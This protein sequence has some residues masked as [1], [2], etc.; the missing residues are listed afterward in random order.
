MSSGTRWLQF[1]YFL[2]FC[3]L[4]C[5][6][7]GWAGKRGSL[8]SRALDTS[9]E[10]EEPAEAASSWGPEPL[11]KGGHRQRRL[12]ADEGGSDR[13]DQPPPECHLNRNLKARWG[14]GKLSSADVQDIAYDAHRSGAVGVEQLSAAGTYGKYPQNLF[15]DLLRIFGE[16]KGGPPI[17]WVEIPLKS[18]ANVPHPVIWPHK[19]FQAL[20]KDRIEFWNKRIFG[21]EGAC[22][23]FWDSMK[24]TD[25]VRRHPHLP[26]GSFSSMV[27]IGMHGDGG[28]FNKNDAVYSLAW[29]SLLGAGETV[30]TRFLFTVVK[31]TDMVPNTLET[32]LRQFAW[33]CNVLLSG[34]TPHHD[35]NRRPLEGG[36]LD[37]CNGVRG[38]LVQ[39]RGDWEWY[40][41]VFGFPR[42]DGADMMCPY[43]RASSTCRA[44]SWTDFSAAAGW[45]DTLWSHESY[46]RYLGDNGLPIP[47]LFRALG[48][49]LECVSVDVL[50]CVDQGVASHIIANVIWILVVLRGC[51]GGR[52]FGE[53]IKL[54]NDHLKAWQKRMQCKNRLRGTLTQER[55]RQ[56]G[57]WPKFKGKAAETR[58]M[59]RYA[60]YMIQEFGRMDSLDDFT[61]LHDQLAAGVCQHLVSFYDLLY[62]QSQHVSPAAK[63]E[64]ER[65]GMELGA[66]Y[67]RLATMT[68]ER[69][70]RLWKLS[71]KLHLFCHLCHLCLHQIVMGNPRYYWCYG[72]EDLVRILFGISGSVHPKTLAASVLCKWLWCV[73][74]ELH[75]DPGM[76][77]SYA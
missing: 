58:H 43:C 71:P 53:R 12:R 6:P 7:F 25:F 62:S 57:D 70:Q 68:F 46:M 13:G 47:A 72:D 56:S 10:R 29:N 59:A 63:I 8:K 22:Q 61:R 31:K 42:W 60:L 27:S 75:V 11:R 9:S 44:R 48:F 20:A 40:T 51:L 26:E 14:R 36:G 2:L 76:D 38:C 39:A 32:L 24:N 66:M 16:P 28:A 54:A 64:F 67:S 37:L 55:V 50:H 35:W 30:A 34:Q 1:G 73:F 77:C 3:T 69:G 15:R 33:S 4:A 65:I 49:R 23:V 21:S 5:V 18:G 45:R 52:N 19:F 17:D 74:D 41:L